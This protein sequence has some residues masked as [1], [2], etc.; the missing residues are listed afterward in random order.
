M[1]IVLVVAGTNEPSNSNVLA[2]SFSEGLRHE[3]E[4][5]VRKFRL[6][7]MK[8]DH[9]SLSHYEPHSPEEE[10]MKYLRESIESAAG[11]VVATPVWNFGVPA[12]LKN[13]I[14]RMGSFGLDETHSRGTL[15]GLPFFLIFTGGAPAPAWKGMLRKTTSFVCEGLRYFGATHIGT[16]FEPRCT[17][18][19]GKFGL[20]VDK[21]PESL[22]K[23]R[24]DG[25]QFA[26]IAATYARTGR[27]PAHSSLH[28]KGYALA[29]RL[30][31]KF[32]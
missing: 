27:L 30:L 31:A 19:R 5:T 6:K 28:H 8:I 11:L 29:Q 3:P 20:A 21:R 17:L 26:R 13:V 4:I 32:H 14:D 22:E 24:A 23:V 15:K 7:D 16:H 18:G 25:E 12:H 1:H 10:D 2:D 9:F